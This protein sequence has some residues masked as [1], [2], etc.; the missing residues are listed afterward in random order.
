MRTGRSISTQNTVSPIA[1]I[2]PIAKSPAQNA[3][4]LLSIA[5]S[6]AGSSVVSLELHFG[7]SGFERRRRQLRAALRWQG[8]QRAPAAQAEKIFTD[9]RMIEVRRLF[10][11]RGD[12]H[13]AIGH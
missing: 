7:R 11:R 13:L 2:S 1:I 6:L 4:D 3:C 5:G 10:D 8:L 12:Q 9:E